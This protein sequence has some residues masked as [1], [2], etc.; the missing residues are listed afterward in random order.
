MRE[1]QKTM[2]AYALILSDQLPDRLPAVMFHTGRRR[3]LTMRQ[4]FDRCGLEGAEAELG[5]VNHQGRAFLLDFFLHE[6]LLF[7]LMGMKKAASFN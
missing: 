4:Q 2:S 5:A 1:N 7:R 6:N 3:I